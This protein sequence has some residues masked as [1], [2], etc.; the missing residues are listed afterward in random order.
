[1]E[2]LARV[3]A[4]QVDTTIRDT[5]FT[6]GGSAQYAGT[7]VAR[8]SIATDGSFDVDMAEIRE[9][10]HSLES[11]NA[12]PFSDGLYRGVIHG[13]VK[14]DLQADTAHWQEVLKHTESGLRDLRGGNAASN[15]KGNGVCGE[16]NGVEFIQ[17]NQALKMDASGS[18]STD[19][20]Q[21]YIFGAEHYGVSQFQDVQ[22]IIKNPS[23]VSTLDLYGTFGFKMSFACKELNSSRMIRIEAGST[24][25]D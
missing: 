16:L 20:Y 12:Q 4:L 23:P 5:A 25:G 15:G 6:A 3:A 8:N 22:T 17:S 2:R 13:D 9:A 18:A 7:A 14:Y 1:M 11:L 10:V 19:I 24:K 21:S